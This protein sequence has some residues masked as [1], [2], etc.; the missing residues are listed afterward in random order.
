[1]TT[2]RLAA[3]PPHRLEP[4]AL[5]RPPVP[6]ALAA[7][8]H[9]TVTF[10]Y[11]WLPV[12]EFGVGSATD[13]LFVSAVIPQVVIGVVTTS[14]TS[15]LTPELSTVTTRVEFRTKAWT[16]GH[17]VF[18]V[19]GGLT[20]LLYGSAPVWVPWLAPGFETEQ[21]IFVLHLVRIQL[22]G[23]FVTMLLAVTWSAA[24][25]RGRFVWVETSGALAGALGLVVAWLTVTPYGVAAV[26]WALVLRSVLHVVLLLPSLGP[27]ILP[28]RCAVGAD[29]WRRL[30]PLIGGAVYYKADPVLERMLASFA[31]A[32]HLSLFHLAQQLYGVVNQVLTRAVINPI[33]PAL[34]RQAAQ[35]R[36]S[37]FRRLV[38]R[39]LVLCI[40][41]LG[42]VWVAILVIGRP[43]MLAILHPW[44][45]P[46]Q[47]ALLH[48]VLVLL[49]GV[50]FGG[51]AGQVFTVAFYAGGNTATPT[52]TGMV[53][54]TVLIPVKIA[55]FWAG[56]VPG[57]AAATSLHLLA[58][59]VAHHVLLWRDVARRVRAHKL[60]LPV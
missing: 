20:A 10:G 24:Y 22:L 51:A 36:W 49:A 33:M 30:L 55:A 5:V 42:A 58:T 16:F 28:T 11:H 38:T 32:G 14:L 40:V 59:A 35:G 6:I 2:E 8:A 34:A 9:L 29:V 18:V 54:F 48:T 57:L 26:A 45:T 47:I 13:A 52:L 7:A 17:I 41:L 4:P 21:Q 44:L 56:G 43:L 27:Y 23:A 1:M 25:A 39:R 19:A 46:D 53:G 15:V 31:L 37:A 3:Q 60:P 50:W 12:V